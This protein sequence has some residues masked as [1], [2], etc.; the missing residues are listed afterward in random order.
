MGRSRTFSKNKAVDDGCDACRGLAD[1]DHKSRAFPC[2]KPWWQL[3]VLCGMDGEL[4]EVGDSRVEH[5][6]VRDVERRGLELFEHN[7]GHALPVGGGVPGG[8]GDEHGMLGG[9][10]AHDI[11]E[12]VRDEGG[13]RCEVRDYRAH[14]YLVQRS[15]PHCMA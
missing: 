8:L 11:P 3:E 10:A 2:C 6:C 12:R 14:T 4:G 5:A 7:L 13:Y 1:V 15:F 9:V